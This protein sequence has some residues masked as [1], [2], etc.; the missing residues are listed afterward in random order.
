MRMNICCEKLRKKVV[1]ED[2]LV[3]CLHVLFVFCCWWLVLFFKGIRKN[4]QKCISCGSQSTSFLKNKMIMRK[5]IKL[6]Y[7][8]NWGQDHK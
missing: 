3:F 4:G 8:E 5:D 7:G 2:F 6:L 1:Y